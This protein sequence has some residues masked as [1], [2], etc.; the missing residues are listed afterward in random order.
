MNVTNFISF[1]NF[2]GQGINALES[3]GAS[4]L[5]DIHSRNAL[6]WIRGHD[7]DYQPN[8]E[9]PYNSRLNKV[10]ATDAPK[11]ECL[12]TSAPLA[13][14]ES[15][16]QIIKKSKPKYFIWDLGGKYTQ[17]ML[18]KISAVLEFNGYDLM[19]IKDSSERLGIPYRDTRYI[20]L[21]KREEDIILLP[22]S[23]EKACLNNLDFYFNIKNDREADLVELNGVL[24]QEEV[25][26]WTHVCVPDGNIL[27]EKTLGH[28]YGCIYYV[29]NDK[30]HRVTAQECSLLLEQGRLNLNIKNAY[31]VYLQLREMPYLM[32]L[33]YIER[34][35]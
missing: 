13:V 18:K 23:R 17:A 28:K 24:Y 11:A 31:E 7:E 34:L 26:P 9:S 30:V 35:I 16:T 6:G 2:S 22:S 4:L 20:M 21:G 27:I 1:F 25:R 32:W 8:L 3:K 33:D 5:A 29:I 19:F 10:I 12:I 14:N 15:V